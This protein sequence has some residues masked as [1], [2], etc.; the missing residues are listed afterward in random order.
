MPEQGD[1]LLITT[2]LSTLWYT[3]KCICQCLADS[4]IPRVKEAM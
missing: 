1:V 3:I 2:C 4:D